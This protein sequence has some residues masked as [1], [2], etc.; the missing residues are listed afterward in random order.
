MKFCFSTLG[1]PDYPF[2]R[3]IEL[4]RRVGY[5]GIELRIYK[6]AE[7]LRTIDELQPG[8]IAQTGRLF[9]NAGLD[10]ACVSSSARFAFPDP[11]NL[12]AQLEQA[13]DYIRMAAALESPYVRVFGGPYPVNFSGRPKS[14]PFIEAY[15]A[16]LPPEKTRGLT[17]EIC[18]RAVMD[19]L[20]EIGEFG[21]AYGVMPLMETHDDFCSG[22][23]VSALIDGC[24]SDNVGIVWD[25]LHPYRYGM[26]LRETYEAVRD[27]I[28]HVHMKDATDLTPW[29][30]MPTLAGEGQMDLRTAVNILR[31]NDFSEYICFEWEKLWY[32]QIADADIACPQFMQKIMELAQG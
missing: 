10:I 30:F 4:V 31:D 13:R 23:R 24:G 27:R 32:P 12:K 2:D 8:K 14:E 17:R 11:E 29:G 20:G 19:C 3:I 1:C 22:E 9:K 7:D 15:R 21:R 28:H 26:D 6:N 18:D 16:S 5:T 25:C